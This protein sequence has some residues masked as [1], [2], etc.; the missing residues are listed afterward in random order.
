MHSI[1]SSSPLAP[2]FNYIPYCVSYPQYTC[3]SPV[4]WLHEYSSILIKESQN[5]YVPSIESPIKVDYSSSS[6][7]SSSINSYIDYSEPKFNQSS[8]LPTFQP[9]STQ[10]VSTDSYYSLNNTSSSYNHDRCSG[11]D[12][13]YLQ[14]EHFTSAKNRM[15]SRKQ[16][17]SDEAVEIMN[18]WFEDHVNN[19]YPQPE[20]KER[21]A[22]SGNITV[23]QV[24]AWFSNRRNRTQNTKPKRM[25]RVFD[26]QIN[27]VFAR[28]VEDKPDKQKMI[29]EF[30][31][32]I[33]STNF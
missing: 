12:A 14:E 31:C 29:D 11:I 32:T 22:F 15:K 13:S 33:N 24:T 3:E 25:R 18:N 9:N 23:K 27:S 21:M 4:P 10:R 19:P 7:S 20:E 26:Q 28:I 5:F 1:Y 30:K 16:L 8:P 6:S 2:S 17:L